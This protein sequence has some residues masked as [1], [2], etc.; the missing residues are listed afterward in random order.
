[1]TNKPDDS[2]RN[3]RTAIVV[4]Q[5]VIRSLAAIYRKDESI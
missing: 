1:M 2:Q 3:D 4:R 5:V